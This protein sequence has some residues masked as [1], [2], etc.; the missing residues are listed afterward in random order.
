MLQQLF[1]LWGYPSAANIKTAFNFRILETLLCGPE[2]GALVTE[3]QEN[4]SWDQTSQWR[5]QTSTLT[6]QYQLAIIEA[7]PFRSVIARETLSSIKANVV[8]RLQRPKDH[9]EG[10]RRAVGHGSGRVC[11]IDKQ[12]VRGPLGLCF[13]SLGTLS[14][15]L[16]LKES[17]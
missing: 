3:Q 14:S 7:G 4:G 1:S 11:F 15:S 6:L 8:Y 17:V 16:P 5:E 10:S 12:I 9:A 2:A 13:Q